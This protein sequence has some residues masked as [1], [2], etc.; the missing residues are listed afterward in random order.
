MEFINSD[1]LNL[2]QNWELN[3]DEL[4]VF[5][6]DVDNLVSLVRFIFE[7][8]IWLQSSLNWLTD[9]ET[10]QG[11]ARTNCLETAFFSY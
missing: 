4:S 8:K 7:I 1:F 5:E 2:T 10:K 3:F 11:R 6:D 9:N